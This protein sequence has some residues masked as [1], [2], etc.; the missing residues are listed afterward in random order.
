MERTFHIQCNTSYLSGGT[1]TVKA[2]APGAG[3]SLAAC[4]TACAQ[5]AECVGAVWVPPEAASRNGG[6]SG[7]FLKEALELAV[8]GFGVEGIESGVWLQ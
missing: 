8:T 2:E 4:L 7:C 6:E 1:L 5:D 3:D